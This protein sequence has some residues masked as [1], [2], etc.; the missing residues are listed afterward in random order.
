MLPLRDMLSKQNSN[1][2]HGWLGQVLQ[3]I[4]VTPESPAVET[5]S[6]YA[7]SFWVAGTKQTFPWFHLVVTGQLKEANHAV[8]KMNMHLDWA[9]DIN[10][11]IEFPASFSHSGSA[12]LCYQK[13]PSQ[14]FL[15]TCWNYI[16][17]FFL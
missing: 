12:R 10:I 1:K 17:D 13:N 15:S 6:A 5:S 14:L 2:V 9:V 3:F 4:K 11:G 16:A 8:F 7:R